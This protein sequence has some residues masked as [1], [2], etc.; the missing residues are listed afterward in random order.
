MIRNALSCT[1]PALL[2]QEAKGQ[3]RRRQQGVFLCSQGG[4]PHSWA[5]VLLHLTS[6]CPHCCRLVLQAKE[7]NGA[8]GKASSHARKGGHSHGHVSGA[9]KV[10]KTGADDK[11]G[12]KVCCCS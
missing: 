2:A 6:F 7:Q 5:H 1:C 12:G 3:K 8:G 11:S 9:S 4:S 10:Q